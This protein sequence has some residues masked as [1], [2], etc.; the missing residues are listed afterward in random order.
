MKRFVFVACMMA[1]IFGFHSPV[2]ASEWI[3]SQNGEIDVEGLSQVSF[4]IIYNNTDDW[5]QAIAWDIDLFVDTTELTPHYNPDAPA[6]PSFEQQYFWV[7][8]TFEDVMGNSYGALFAENGK[9]EGNEFSTAGGTLGAPI[10]IAPGENNLATITFDILNPD[11]S[12]GIVEADLYVMAN[13]PLRQEGFTA[14]D[15]SLIAH[16]NSDSTLNA[17]IVNPVPVPAAA[18]LLGSGLVGLVGL[19]RRSA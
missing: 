10:W 4:D 3:I 19:R 2:M 8:F 6:P 5:F 17:D 12:N 14:A 16:V 15:A 11:E 9:L 1:M 13:D 18:W 7:D